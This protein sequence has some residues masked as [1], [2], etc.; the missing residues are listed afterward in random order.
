MPT[1]HRT[2]AIAAAILALSALAA[3]A[4][5]DTI[6]LHVASQHFPEKNFNNFNPGLYYRTDAGWTAGFYRNSL[7]RESVYGGYTWSYAGIE[8]TTGLVTGY[9]H[10]VQVLAVPSLTLFTY[11]GVTPRLAYIPRVE[12]KVGAQ[13]LHLMLEYAL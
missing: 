3:S 6:G 9:Q 11:K 1:P 7:R 8:L 10:K 5:A 13:V 12:K 4:R 2:L